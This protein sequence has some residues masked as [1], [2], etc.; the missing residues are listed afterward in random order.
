[1]SAGSDDDWVHAAES[2]TA[3]T[4]VRPTGAAVFP[5]GFRHDA[6]VVSPLMVYAEPAVRANLLGKLMRQARP[7]DV[8]TFATPETI[9]ASWGD[10]ERYLG[11]SKPF[12]R[13]LMMRWQLLPN[14][15]S[16]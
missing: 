4:A 8:L 9:A 7:D 10:V 1:M 13:W 5:L 15:E 6:G 11:K 16:T 2:H 14:D 3:R 12:W